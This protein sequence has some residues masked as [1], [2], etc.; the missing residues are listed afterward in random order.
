MSNILRAPNTPVS[1]AP[2]HAG[3][4]FWDLCVLQGETTTSLEKFNL[5]VSV[6][7]L[8]SMSTFWIMT[9]AAGRLD[10]RCISVQSALLKALTSDV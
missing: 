2:T 8:V 7:Y 4:H 1:A 3:D 5:K 10:S 6:L 9:I